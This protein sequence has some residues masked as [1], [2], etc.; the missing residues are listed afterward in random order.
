MIPKNKIIMS[1][2]TL[3]HKQLL[4]TLPLPMLSNAAHVC[5]QLHLDFCRS[6]IN[7][8]C[9][10]GWKGSCVL[11]WRG[12]GGGPTYSWFA[13]T[14]PPHTHHPTVWNP[15]AV[16]PSRGKSMIIPPF[17]CVYETSFI[18]HFCFIRR[19]SL[20][21]VLALSPF[22]Q[23]L[24]NQKIIHNNNNRKRTINPPVINPS[25]YLEPTI[26]NRI[27]LRNTQITQQ[28]IKKNRK[29]KKKDRTKIDES[30]MLFGWKCLPLRC[31]CY[32]NTTPTRRGEMF[33]SLAL[34]FNGLFCIVPMPS[35]I[36]SICS[37]LWCALLRAI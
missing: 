36:Y 14:S 2:W 35:I 33:S 4:Y 11:W 29:K 3:A 6:G 10:L 18:Q 21:S 23:R 28:K 22:I 19:K 37:M 34:C 27:I 24:I 9:D 17:I 16:H 5:I 32:A 12:G 7:T 13:W 26:S 25:L 30:P 8:V 31:C 1:P 15:P 20:K